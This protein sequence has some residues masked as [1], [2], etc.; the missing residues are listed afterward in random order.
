MLQ[1]RRDMEIQR[2]DMKLQR[3]DMMKWNFRGEKTEANL[4]YVIGTLQTGKQI[5]ES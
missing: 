4:L 2:R 5:L 3:Q 1:K